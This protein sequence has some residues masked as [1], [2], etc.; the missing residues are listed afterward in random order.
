[1]KKTIY[2]VFCAI[3][4]ILIGTFSSNS[5]IVYAA[6]PDSVSDV[7]S[8]D[9]QLYDSLSN[10][11]PIS[12]NGVATLEFQ[13]FDENSTINTTNNPYGT[14]YIGIQVN[15]VPVI[16]ESLEENEK[17]AIYG[18]VTASIKINGTPVTFENNYATSQDNYILFTQSTFEY[19]GNSR[20]YIQIVPIKPG[21]NII[22]CEVYGQRAQLTINCEYAMPSQ[23][24]LEYDLSLKN[25]LLESYEPITFTV[26]PNYQKWLDPNQQIIY[27][28][29]LN[30]KIISGQTS[31][32]FTVTKDMIAVGKY[33]IAVT[34]PNT[35]LQA[36]DNIE[37]KTEIKYV[38]DITHNGELE[39]TYGEYLQ[40]ISFSASIPVQDSYTID[41][42][43]KTPQSEIYTY[44]QT[45][46]NFDFIHTNYSAGIYKIFA[47]ARL[48][49]ES[50][51][52]PV[53][54]VTIHQKQ[55]DETINLTI[56][57]NEVK[58][59]STGLT[60]FEF[61]IQ[62]LEDETF[63]IQNY[64]EADSIEWWI[65]DD[66]GNVSRA[67][68]GYTF[69]FPPTEINTYD[70]RI[71]ARKG[72]SLINLLQNQNPDYIEVTPR[73]VGQAIN[74]WVYVIVAAVLIMIIGVV[75]IIISNKAREKIW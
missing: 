7:S 18:D 5:T 35:E 45:S 8:L 3:M 61:S 53:Q 23:L 2:C 13:T 32:S 34:V 22:E 71:Y 16:Y 24:S 19:Y 10:I 51:Y 63:D 52:S 21:P 48:N 38:V 12:Q 14:Y 56:S 65:S 15:T 36:S 49:S 6:L 41:W 55:I 47:V 25:Q 58:N 39:F 11:T 44:E 26:K 4:L 37:I 43:L 33:T 68:I 73:R 46:Q 17:L 1:M 29:A 62:N 20:I 67:G 70:V 57:V 60:S 40:P 30:S 66:S 72:G 50:Y 59:Q 54:V 75:S 74:I 64:Y 27:E 42:Y 69:N 31:D 9:M 28:W